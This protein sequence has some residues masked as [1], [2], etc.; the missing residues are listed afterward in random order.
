MGKLKTTG[1]DHS[2]VLS[3]KPGGDVLNLEISGFV[4]DSDFEFRSDPF[5]LR[6][7]C[8]A[9]LKF[10]F[11]GDLAAD[12]TDRFNTPVK[13]DLITTPFAFQGL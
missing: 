2:F 1:L 8:L 9:W 12:R 6:F 11:H 13:L 3:I 7:G 5:T 4:F 10:A